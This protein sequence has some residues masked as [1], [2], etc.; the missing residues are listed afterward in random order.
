M[1]QLNFPSCFSVNY[2]CVTAGNLKF[3]ATIYIH[4][5]AIEIVWKPYRAVKRLYFIHYDYKYSVYNTL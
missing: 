3:P 5:I 4:I 2:K 1:S